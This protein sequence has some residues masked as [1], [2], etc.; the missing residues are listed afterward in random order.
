MTRYQRA[1]SVLTV[2]L[3]ALLLATAPAAA[4]N[5]IDPIV[6]AI[7]PPRQAPSPQIPDGWASEPH[8][9]GMWARY[10]YAGLRWSTYDQT[11][12]QQFDTG[13]GVALNDIATTI[14]QL[15]NDVQYEALN[16]D[17]ATPLDRVLTRGLG[18]LFRGFVA[19]WMG[20]AAAALA[21]GVLAAAAGGGR[22][23][24]GGALIG[25]ALVVIGGLYAITA[26]PTAV[27]AA[28]DALTVNVTTRASDTLT[29]LNPG[30][31]GGD[32]K[33]RFA[34]AYYQVSY[35]AWTQGS[36]CG[37]TGAAKEFGP[38]FVDDGAYTVAQMRATTTNPGAQQALVDAKAQAWARDAEDLKTAHPAAFTCWSGASGGRFGAGAKHLIV[39]ISAGAFVLA[40]SGAELVLRDMLRFA[41]LM[42]IALGAV[43]L[44]SRKMTSRYLEWVLLAALGAPAVALATAVLLFGYTV[45]LSDPGQAWWRA[46]FAAIALGLAV[47]FSMRHLRGMLLG[48]AVLEGAH[49]ATHRAGRRGAH[50]ARSA[51]G[52]GAQTAGARAGATVGAVTAAAAATWHSTGDERRDEHTVAPVGD[53]QRA[54]VTA[55]AGEAFDHGRVIYKSDGAPMGAH[56][57][58]TTGAGTL[59]DDPA[60]TRAPDLARDTL[61]AYTRKAREQGHPAPADTPPGGWYK[62]PAP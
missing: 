42:G 9:G 6:K 5:P 23:S 53:T 18:G 17:T 58:T 54:P 47:I 30:Q 24:E 20:W 51:L 36:F 39:S 22:L 16:P 7:C 13:T 48:I 44:V 1:A 25:S 34:E 4:W 2:A 46:A 33:T 50:R 29:K 3:C 43:L 61:D 56:D 38:R 45:I 62:A 15:V 27:P 12:S 31:G 35:A 14:D 37:D 41:I 11:C 60:P 55:R 21:L 32:A 57:D 28:A 19:P 8:D 40:A 10:R 49:R 26:H 59:G 52:G